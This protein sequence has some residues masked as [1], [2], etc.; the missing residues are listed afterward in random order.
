MTIV[1]SNS[2]QNTKTPGKRGPKASG[3]VGIPVA[4]RVRPEHL[5]RLD[6]YAAAKGIARAS[7]IQIAIAEMLERAGISAK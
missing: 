4:V 6:E 7:A 2:K 1:A 3:D 5:V